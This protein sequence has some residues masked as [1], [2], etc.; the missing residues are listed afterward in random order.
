MNL[1]LIRHGES[2]IPEDRVQHDYPL[3]ALGREQAQRL[4][5][6]LRGMHIDRLITTPFKRTLETAAAVAATTGVDLVEEPGLGAIDAGELQRVPFSQRTER[7]PDYYA[8][9]AAPLMDYSHFGGESALGFYERVT[10]AFVE[11]V[12][13]RHR[14]ERVTV[15]VVCH[16]ETINAILHH[17]LGTPFDG[18][19]TFSIDHTAVSLLD[20]RLDRPRVRYINDSN[21]LG[22]LSRGHRGQVGGE[23]PRPRPV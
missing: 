3:S 11:R 10:P 20:V 2:D 19:M 6:R 15:V 13:E 21:H 4:G 14:R 23:T 12:W 16:A 9:P 22:E 17:L 18:W 5:E 7:W 1:Y 8:R